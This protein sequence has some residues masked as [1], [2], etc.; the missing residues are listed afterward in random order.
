[1]ADRHDSGKLSTYLRIGSESDNLSCSYSSKMPAAVNCL[2]IDPVRNFV[3]TC[4]AAGFLEF[5]YAVYRDGSRAHE[6]LRLAGLLEIIMEFSLKIGDGKKP[7]GS[8]RANEE[9]SNHQLEEK[10]S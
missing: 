6:S 5:G 2:P 10:N 4:P 1:M 7:T 9:P 8:K 3:S